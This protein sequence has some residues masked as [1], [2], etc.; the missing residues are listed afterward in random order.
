MNKQTKPQKIQEG[1]TQLE[2][3]LQ[4]SVAPFIQSLAVSSQS[5]LLSRNGL[6]HFS[7]YQL[8]NSEVGQ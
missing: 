6:I 8:I 4:T 5:G 3:D 7:T 2:L 1:E